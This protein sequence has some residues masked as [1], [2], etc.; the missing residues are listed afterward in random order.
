MYCIASLT[1]LLVLMGKGPQSRR[2]A[3]ETSE[4]HT[5]Q[6]T[7]HNSL[8]MC[9]LLPGRSGSWGIYKIC[10]QSITITPPLNAYLNIN[11]INEYVTKEQL[12]QKIEKKKINFFCS[13]GRYEPK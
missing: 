9:F 12:C 8:T 4:K 6:R 7:E 13:L 3:S 5:T 11:F 1:R 2:K 10:F